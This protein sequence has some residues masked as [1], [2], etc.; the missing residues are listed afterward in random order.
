MF[1][2]LLPKKCRQILKCVVQVSYRPF[3]HP[4]CVSALEYTVEIE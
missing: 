4:D 1:V 2:L 3:L